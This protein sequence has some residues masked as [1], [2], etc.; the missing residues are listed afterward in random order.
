[1]AMTPAERQ[2]KRRERLRKER[3]AGGRDASRKG[4]HRPEDEQPDG[5]RPEWG[6]SK[7][8]REARREEAA[9]QAMAERVE[10][11][12]AQPLPPP[13]QR[14]ER[15]LR[16]LLAL[17]EEPLLQSGARVGAAKLLLEDAAHELSG[18]PGSPG[19]GDGDAPPASLE[20]S[21]RQ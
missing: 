19:T 7:A 12:L 8:Q 14:R 5:R 15:T 3:L 2:Q 17:V 6:E 10:Q 4:R 18:K 1:M 9:V 16:V 13:H 20:E 11:L 21:L